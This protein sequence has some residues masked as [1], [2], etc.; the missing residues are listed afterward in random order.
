MPIAQLAV[1][2]AFLAVSGGASA[3]VH[4]TLLAVFGFALLFFGLVN[5]VKL[6]TGQSNVNAWMH[7]RNLDPE[8]FRRRNKELLMSDT[9]GDYPNDET[10]QPAARDLLDAVRKLITADT[11]NADEWEKAIQQGLEAIRKANGK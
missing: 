3:F 5:A 8:T 9:I 10:L 7:N 4:Q 11:Q 6:L 2:V 1:A